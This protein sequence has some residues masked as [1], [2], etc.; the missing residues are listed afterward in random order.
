MIHYFF[1]YFSSLIF[2]SSPTFTKLLFYFVD[3]EIFPIFFPNIVDII[4]II[5]FPEYR[6]LYPWILPTY[7]FVSFYLNRNHIVI[8][9]GEDLLIMDLPL[10]WSIL[11]LIFHN[12]VP[13]QCIIITSQLF[14]ILTQLWMSWMDWKEFLPHFQSH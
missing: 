7:F 6:D 3:L 11:F 1:H 12:Q 8:C 13:L 10:I 5:L 9:S 14:M 2:Q 4:Y